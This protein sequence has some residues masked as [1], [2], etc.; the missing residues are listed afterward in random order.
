[1]AERKNRQLLEVV[2]ASLLEAHMPTRYWGE[3][4]T[5]ATYLINKLPSSTLQF[6]TPL[7]VLHDAINTPTVSNLPPKVFGC[8]TFVHL[9]KPLRNKLEPRALKCVFV[10]YAQHQKGYRCYHPSTHKLYVTLDVVFQEDKMYYSTPE[11]ISDEDNQGFL[12]APKDNLYH[13][14]VI[15]GNITPNL[16]H[17]LQQ[18]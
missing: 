16:S 9:H 14:D 18:R 13:L 7:S 2:R 11:M 5:T 10:G 4:I 17:M 1:M 6:Q 3:A 15:C 8:T 12:Q